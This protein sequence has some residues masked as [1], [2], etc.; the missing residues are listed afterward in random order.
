[1]RAH[2]SCSSQ[3]LG[4]SEGAS[5]H[6]GTGYGPR[7]ASASVHDDPHIQKSGSAG[8]IAQLLSTAE[9][10]THLRLFGSP[11]SGRPVHANP[12]ACARRRRDDLPRRELPAS[13]TGRHHRMSGGSRGVGRGA[14]GRPAEGA[15]V[16]A[17]ALDPPYRSGHEAVLD[18]LSRQ[19]STY[20]DCTA[21]ERESGPPGCS[22]I[23]SIRDSP[24]CVS[25]GR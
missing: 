22:D 8:A 17:V 7:S 25:T 6:T 12:S 10:L 23:S 5:R 4:P 21:L 20:I 1:M 14:Q 18:S 19:E 3:R 9:P 24:W 15:W 11:R 2:L 13:G 16:H